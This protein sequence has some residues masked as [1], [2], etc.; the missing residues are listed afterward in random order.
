VDG[1]VD[2]G[3]ADL[4]GDFAYPLPVIVIA[5]MLG[6]SRDDRA[7][8]KQW[9]DDMVAGQSGAEGSLAPDLRARDEFNA[10]F[11]EALARRRDLETKGEALPDDLVSALFLADYDGRRLDE[12]QALNTLQQLLVAGN[13]T[14]TSLLSNL[15]YRLFQ[16]PEQLAQVRDEPALVEAAVEESLRFDSPVQGLFRTNS[17]PTTVHGVDLEQDT[18]VMVLYASANRDPEVWER[19]D[20]FDIDRDLTEL[21]RHY[22]F[23][24]GVHL[25]LGAPLARLEGRIGVE[26]LLSRLPGLRP[27]GEPEL[28]A[29]M[30]MRGFRRM[31]IA[32]DV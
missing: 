31:P 30:L 32:W 16:Q 27:A 10:Y 8:F 29:P 12:A 20:E 2:R 28:M 17:R 25:C 24:H 7:T 23:G 9:S 1:F 15:F 26:T 18:K 5:E 4:V 22:A 14:T 3:T 6:V 11:A 21:R 19:P 13:E